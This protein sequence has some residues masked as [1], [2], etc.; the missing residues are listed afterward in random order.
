M[1]LPK[2][3]LPIFELELP[4]TGEKLSY[5]PFTVKEEKILLVAQESNE[6]SQEIIATKQVVNN[7]LIG[8]DISDLAMFD[9]EY[10]LLILRSRSVD[11]SITFNIKDPE[12]KET[13]NLVLDIETIQ[14]VRND[15]HKKEV[16]INSEYTLYLKYPTIQQYL[17][18]SSMDANDPLVN[19]YVMVSCL[20]K[21][22]SED[23]I[24]DFK[25]YTSEEID[26]FMEGVTGEVVKAIQ[27]F[28]ETMPVLRHE[29]KYTNEKGNEQTFVLEGMRTFF[30]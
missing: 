3:D 25:D 13:V 5:R 8:K 29:L 9:L 1:G 20:D 12:T 2:I 28:F 27:Q 19:Y 14:L 26:T 7:C 24:H 10:V 23:E 4:S 16:K 30:M 21:V 6:P 15:D 22:A 18:I 11:N 17:D